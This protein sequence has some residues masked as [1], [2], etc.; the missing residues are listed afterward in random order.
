ME[1]KTITYLG[2]VNLDEL[3]VGILG[4]WISLEL[5][6]AIILILKQQAGY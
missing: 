4:S 6:Q 5:F 3:Q 2:K 1:K